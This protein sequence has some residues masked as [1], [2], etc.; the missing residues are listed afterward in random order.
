MV[1]QLPG[2]PPL[3]FPCGLSD[4]MPDDAHERRPTVG[5][6]SQEERSSEATRFARSPTRLDLRAGRTVA[7]LHVAA[8]P[9]MRDTIDGATRYPPTQMN[10]GTIFTP[11]RT[12]DKVIRRATQISSERYPPRPN[13]RVMRPLDSGSPCLFWSHFPCNRA[14]S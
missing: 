3:E 7:A 11:L 4:S 13:V 6:P 8:V 12:Q 5:R 1:D 10:R 14:F 2:P 9:M